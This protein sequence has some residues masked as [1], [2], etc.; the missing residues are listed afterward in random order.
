MFMF[1]MSSFWQP[2]AEQLAMTYNINKQKGAKTVTG[3]ELNPYFKAEQN[4]KKKIVKDTKL[5]FKLLKK[6]FYERGIS[7]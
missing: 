4:G 7:R 6:H 3:N 5:G 2:F 1:K